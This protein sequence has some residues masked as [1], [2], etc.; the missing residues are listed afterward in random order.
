VA[1]P[2]ALRRPHV[3]EAPGPLDHLGEH[4]EDEDDRQRPWVAMRQ[5]DRECGNRG[6]AT[7]TRAVVTGDGARLHVAI[8]ANVLEAAWGGIPKYLHRIAEELAAGG[9]RV[10]LLINRRGWTTTI[11]GAHA[12]NLRLRGRPLWRELAVPAW[13]LRHRPDVLWAPEGVLPRRGPLPGVVTVHDLAPLLLPGTKPP[14][15]EQEYRTSRPRSARSAARV[16]CVSETTARDVADQWGV[17]RD[18]L[19]VVPNGV[20]ERF[21]PGDTEIARATVRER[22]GVQGPFVLHVGSIEPR[23]GLEVLFSASAGADWTLVLAGSPGFKGEGLVADASRAGAV[24]IRGADDDDLVSLYRAAEAVA[25]PALY[26][27]FGIVPL[28]AMACGTPAVVAANAGALEE[29]SGAAAI[30]VAD[31]DPEAWRAGIAEARRRRPELATTGLA[32]AARFRWPQVAAATRAVLV[33]A[34]RGRGPS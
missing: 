16:I 15:L 22:Y 21:R 32:H 3:L 6:G 25:A 33:D 2:Q 34:A 8:D 20:D 9:D 27:G 12:V 19:A 13:M 14:A 7:Y 24:L 10:D 29:V 30:V 1:A 18:R 11:P 23:K 17:P 4:R 28:E 26:E 5:P 31:R